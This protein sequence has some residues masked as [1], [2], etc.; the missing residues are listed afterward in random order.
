VA[1]LLRAR[2][3][4]ADRGLELHLLSRP[5]GLV[6]RVLQFSGLEPVPAG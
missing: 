1:L 4:A 6:A 5:S 3:E 2:A